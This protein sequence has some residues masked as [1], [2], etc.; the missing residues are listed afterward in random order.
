[1]IIFGVSKTGGHIYPAIA[2]A[3]ETSL[4]TFFVGPNSSLVKDVIQRYGFSFYP[5]STVSKNPLKVVLSIMSCCF[6]LKKYSITKV[7][8]TG[9]FSTVPLLIAAWICRKPIYLLEQNVLPGRV[10]LWFSKIARAV[11][12][13]FDESLSYFSSAS[14][15]SRCKVLGNPIRKTFDLDEAGRF[16]SR[17]SLSSETCLL[18]VG[19]SQGAEKIN[20]WISGL[21]T[22]FHRDGISVIHITGPAYYDQKG[23]DGAY[24]CLSSEGEGAQTVIIPY[25]EQMDAAYQLSTIVISRAGATTISELIAFQ[26]PSLLIPYPYA[27]DDH[28]RLNA[29]CLE[30]YGVAREILQS[31]LI[32]LDYPALIALMRDPKL[33]ETAQEKSALYHRFLTARETIVT[34]LLQS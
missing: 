32:T 17:L 9:G 5:Y 14:S 22:R 1:M 31:R 19:G 34:A 27:K 33:R 21:Y 8:G 3:Q 2:L 18:V 29:E 13:S 30:R 11:Y 12:V 6:L 26:K 28:Q 10:T 24:H 4:Q 20:D 23:Y 25:L 15:R 16:L 7:V